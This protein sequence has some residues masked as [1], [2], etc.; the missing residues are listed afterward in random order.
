MM[1]G[2][3]VSLASMATFLNLLDKAFLII[4]IK[5]MCLTIYSANEE[6]R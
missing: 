6:F 3:P 5:D 2:S 1:L 4:V